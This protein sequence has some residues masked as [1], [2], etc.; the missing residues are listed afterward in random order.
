MI[1]A[2]AG[3][4]GGARF[5][6]GLALCLP[7]DDLTV[8]VN[9]GD[10]F[11]HLGLHI[12]PDPDTVLYTLSGLADRER[13]WGRHDETWNFMAA[14]GGIGGETWFQLGDKDLSLH[15]E[16]TRRLAAGET[17]SAIT[18][19]LAR[20]LGI[21][22][23]IV[24]MSDDPAPTLVHTVEGTLSFQD[25]FVRRRCEPVAT[26]V[27]LGGAG[28]ATPSAAFRAAMESPVLT[29]I[30][31]CPSNPVLS[32]DPIL[33]V[34][35]VRD[36]LTNRRVP[37]VAISPLI[38]GKAVKGPAAK[39]M[40]ELALEPTVHGIARHFDG[41]ID[42][43]VIDHQDSHAIAPTSKLAIHATDAVMVGEEGRKRLADETLQF[44]ATLPRR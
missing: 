35:G 26:R 43:L 19:D 27:E 37:C 41:L 23:A 32:I 18:A 38:G 15:V 3:G 25:Y 7:A 39:I 21:G 14:L 2:L 36:W 4:V 30:V 34:V 16:R 28:T 13:G 9:T 29:G 24:P 8:V 31:I 6:H 10:D 33:S 11:R 1:V 20:K 40:G 22:S 44:L 42:G 5:A 17:L 12:S